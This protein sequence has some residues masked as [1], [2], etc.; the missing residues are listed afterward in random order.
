MLVCVIM[1]W[2][3]IKPI[4]PT[5]PDEPTSDPVDS[6]P[7]TMLLPLNRR[8]DPNGVLLPSFETLTVFTCL[9]YSGEIQPY[10]PKTIF[11]LGVACQPRTT[12]C[13][14]SQEKWDSTTYSWLGG[15]TVS[16]W[17]MIGYTRGPSVQYLPCTILR[18]LRA[19]GLLRAHCLLLQTDLWGA[20]PPLAIC[21]QFPKFSFSYFLPRACFLTIFAGTWVISELLPPILNKSP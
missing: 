21:C 9:A 7:V 2:L 5:T 4:R 1:A 13:H 3:Y 14:F 8:P 16:C 17:F 10:Y 11:P 20:H 15:T 19:P 18:F 6:D 12:A